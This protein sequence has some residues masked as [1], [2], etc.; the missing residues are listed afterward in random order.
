M[1]Y[2]DKVFKARWEEQHQDIGTL[3]GE[4]ERIMRKTVNVD[5]AK[6]YDTDR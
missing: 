4:K 6:A 5:M 3:H 1:N 2:I